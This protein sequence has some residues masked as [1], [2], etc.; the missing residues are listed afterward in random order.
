MNT[1]DC[2]PGQTIRV[3]LAPPL[4]G[5]IEGEVL[6]TDPKAVHLDA[7]NTN[8]I[9]ID[10]RWISHIRPHQSHPSNTNPKENQ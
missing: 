7:F 3:H 1:R 9:S 10:L 4:R 8:P 6:R 5:W 2:T